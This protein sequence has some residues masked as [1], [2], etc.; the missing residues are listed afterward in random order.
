MGLKKGRRGK[1]LVRGIVQPFNSVETRRGNAT[2][3][4]FA[5]RISRE[6]QRGRR[7][8]IIAVIL[9]NERCTRL[10]IQVSR[11]RREEKDDEAFYQTEKK[12]KKNTNDFQFYRIDLHLPSLSSSR[13]FVFVVVIGTF[14]PPPPP[15]SRNRSSKLISLLLHLLLLL[16]IRWGAARNGAVIHLAV[17]IRP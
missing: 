2:G 12:K 13:S 8:S 15:R 17:V 10:E 16:E 3:E 14:Q 6:K 7:T 4:H 11:A 1:Q 9:L 5:E